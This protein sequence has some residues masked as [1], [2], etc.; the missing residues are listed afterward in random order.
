M[1]LD[2]RTGTGVKAAETQVPEQ[3]AHAWMH[4][5]DGWVK[6][7][8]RSG[9]PVEE[10][11]IQGETQRSTFFRVELGGKNIIP[12]DRAGKAQAVIGLAGTVARI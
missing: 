11:A 7:V 8:R 4:I 3:T 10:I 1:G 12:G 5:D 9:F 2:G 6:E